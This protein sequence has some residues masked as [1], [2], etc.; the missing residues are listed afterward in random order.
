MPTLVASSTW[1]RRP[2]R[3]IH[4]PIRVSDSP[5]WLPGAQREYTSAVSMKFSPASTM[6]S[7]KE[8]APASSTVQPKTLPPKVRRDLQAG[9]AE[10]AL[11]HD[12]V[13]C[14]A[15]GGGR[16]TVP[17]VQCI[18]NGAGGGAGI[19]RARAMHPFRDSPQR[20]LICA[21]LDYMA[22]TAGRT[23]GKPP[24]PP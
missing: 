22:F 17:I 7:S 14:V 15:A 19:R 16:T 6:A 18:G 4:L 5:P 13:L 23:C 24:G 10:R 21:T 20:L 9:T 3:L 8:Q 12:E 2:E 11:D 1:L